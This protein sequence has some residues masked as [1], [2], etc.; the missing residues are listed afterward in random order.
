M[1]ATS[2]SSVGN[3]YVVQCAAASRGRPDACDSNSSIV[4]PGSS[5]PAVFTLNHGR[6]FDTSSSRCSLP[7]SRSCMMA[8]AVKSLLCDAMRNF[9]CGVIAVFAAVS[10]KPNPRLQTSSSP[11]TTPTTTP[12]RPRFRSC[13]SIQAVKSRC[14]PCTSGSSAGP[15]ARSCPERTAPEGRTVSRHSRPATR[16]T[17]KR[18]VL[19][20]IAY[21]LCQVAPLRGVSRLMGG[22]P[23]YSRDVCPRTAPQSV[24]IRHRKMLRRFTS[25]TF[26]AGQSP[27]SQ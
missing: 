9:V 12:G 14:A 16:A 4:I 24:G 5:A 25:R 13:P 7:S 26:S 2:S 22:V 15:R 23:D 3:S 10:A 6:C 11:A 27:M 21:S 19:A 1:R 20:T 18:R 8:V 17:R